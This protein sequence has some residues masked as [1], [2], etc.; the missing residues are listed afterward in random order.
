MA[1]IGEQLGICRY[2]GLRIAR[3]YFEFLAQ[4]TEPQAF[5]DDGQEA[6]IVG[7]GALD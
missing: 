6:G 7:K 3:I 2:R 5:V 4:V 1:L